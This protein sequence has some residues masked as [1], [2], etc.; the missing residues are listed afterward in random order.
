[1]W[2]CNRRSCKKVIALHVIEYYQ[3]MWW[4]VDIWPVDPIN[5]QGKNLHHRY[6]KCKS[7]VRS[8]TRTLRPRPPQCKYNASMN[9]AN[10][11][12]RDVKTIRNYVEYKEKQCA[13]VIRR[14]E[15]ADI[16]KCKSKPWR[17]GHNFAECCPR[18]YD[19]AFPYF[20]D[21]LCPCGGFLPAQRFFR[22]PIS[23]QD[24]VCS[25]N[26]A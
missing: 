12:I 5:A 17:A 25:V 14:H 15:S 20:S 19:P 6:H 22:S 21:C 1:M 10:T 18:C 26:P 7:I 4:V 2:W 11:S 16:W 24:V 8:T 13:L 23:L 3:C 9:P